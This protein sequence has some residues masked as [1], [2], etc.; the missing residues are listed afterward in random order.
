MFIESPL[1]SMLIIGL[2]SAV[3]SIVCYFICCLPNESLMD[4]REMPD[5]R[6]IEDDNEQNPI[7]EEE[8]DNEQKTTVEKKDD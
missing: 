1:L 3:L 6:I 4:E 2:P 5:E 7:E 8:E